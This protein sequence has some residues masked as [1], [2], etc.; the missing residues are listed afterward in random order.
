MEGPPGNLCFSG[1]VWHPCSRPWPLGLLGP[2]G[3]WTQRRSARSAKAPPRAERSTRLGPESESYA[4]VAELNK[5]T[6]PSNPALTETAGQSLAMCGYLS[7]KSGVQEPQEPG[8]ATVR[9][10][11]ALARPVLGRSAHRSRGSLWTPPLAPPSRP[12]E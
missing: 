9:M 3:R 5:G 7:R 12:R 1:W 10:L 8:C 4:Q 11:T 2:L 6:R